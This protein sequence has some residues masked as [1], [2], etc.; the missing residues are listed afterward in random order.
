M[1]KC[2]Y[3]GCDYVAAHII[4]NSHAKKHGYKNVKELTEAHGPIKQLQYDPKKL[5]HA[6]EST[7]IVTE[8]SFN[9]VESAIARLKKS[10]RSELRNRT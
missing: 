10:D 6:R 8:S 1:Y 2:P 9:S 3:P 7:V 4:L 5:K